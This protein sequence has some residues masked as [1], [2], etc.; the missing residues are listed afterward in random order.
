[1]A[2]DNHSIFSIYLVLLRNFDYCRR[3][4]SFPQ[5]ADIQPDSKKPAGLVDRQASWLA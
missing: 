5:D 1:M 3:I 2:L 4:M